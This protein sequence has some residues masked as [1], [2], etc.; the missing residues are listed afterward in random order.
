MKKIFPLY[1]FPPSTKNFPTIIFSLFHQ[2]WYIFFCIIS[3]WIKVKKQQTE[4]LRKTKRKILSLLQ[5]FLW[6]LRF[7][8]LFFLHLWRA[9]LSNTHT[10]TRRE[11]EKKNKLC[12]SWGKRDSWVK[13]VSHQY[14][15]VKKIKEKN[16]RKKRI[17]KKK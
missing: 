11:V 16:T 17:E 15:K 12:V 13:A 9:I 8:Q 5:C 10:H 2:P 1:N 4:M 6:C 3:L 14:Q 7:S